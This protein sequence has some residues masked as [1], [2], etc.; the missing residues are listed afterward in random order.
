MPVE[1]VDFE[2]ARGLNGLR[3]VVVGGVPSPWGE[4]AKGIFHVKGI[5]YVAVH[6]DPMNPQMTEW[7]RDRSAPVALF[8]DEP[9]RGKWDDILSLAERISPEP[10]LLPSD[11]A[12]RAQMME[13]SELLCGVDGLGWCRRLQGVHAGLNEHPGGYKK[14]IAAYL[15]AKYGYN[16][17]DVDRYEERVVSILGSLGGQLQAQKEAGRRYIVGDRLTAA[18]IYCAAFMGIFKP[19]APELCAMRESLRHTFEF[20]DKATTHALTPRLIEHRDFIY[21]KHLELPLSL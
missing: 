7:T 11:D 6:H 9:P 3:L 21:D 18:D 10:S 4:A 17:E 1:Y 5:A 13:L 12:Q 15:G 19:F 2:A 20:L 8:N 16:T 14:G